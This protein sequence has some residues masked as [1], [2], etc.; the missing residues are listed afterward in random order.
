M[1]FNVIGVYRIKNVED[2][3]LIEIEIR[4]SK[5]ALNLS[6]IT[7]PIENLDKL[8]WQ[9]PYKEYLLDVTGK[10]IL[11]KE[12]ENIQDEKLIGYFRI[13][14]FFHFIDIEKPLS[15][16]YGDFKLPPITNL[17]ERLK[18]IQYTKPD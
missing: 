3:H 7:Q 14:F 11:S 4:N 5:I 18:D 17:P 2:S 8:N 13:V 1:E 16:Q 15:T 6:K 9:V 12:W 10:N